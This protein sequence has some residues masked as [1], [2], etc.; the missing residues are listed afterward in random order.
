M[1]TKFTFEPIDLSWFPLVEISVEFVEIL[2]LVSE[3]KTASSRF[4]RTFQSSKIDQKSG[5]AS[6]SKTLQTVVAAHW[7]KNDPFTVLD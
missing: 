5:F 3:T 1:R 2:N 7:S 6:T 4:F